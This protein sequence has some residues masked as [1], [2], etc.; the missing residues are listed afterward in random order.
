MDLGAWWTYPYVFNGELQ[1]EDSSKWLAKWREKREAH[2][3]HM[4]ITKSILVWDCFRADQTLAFSPIK[5]LVIAWE[6]VSS[7]L[8][9]QAKAA[10][11]N[12]ITIQR[13]QFRFPYSILWSEARSRGSPCT[14]RIDHV[15]IFQS[16]IIFYF[17]IGMSLLWLMFV[18]GF[19]LSMIQFLS[20]RY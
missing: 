15:G 16:V 3:L 7:T 20:M 10:A 12:S 14:W 18:L 9:T 11:E 19:C 5:S 17:R 1:A 2:D 8:Q 6:K 13:P 4:G